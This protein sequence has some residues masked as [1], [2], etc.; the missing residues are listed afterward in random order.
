MSPTKAQT[1]ERCAYGDETQDDQDDDMIPEVVAVEGRTTT[2]V[3]IAALAAGEISVTSTTPEEDEDVNN[4]VRMAL[5]RARTPAMAFSGTTHMNATLRGG[6]AIGAGG[7]VKQ[8]VWRRAVNA[9]SE[10]LRSH[11]I[12]IT[13]P[14]PSPAFTWIT[15]MSILSVCKRLKKARVYLE[16]CDAAWRTV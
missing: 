6:R 4:A 1:H 16:T 9:D 2:M 10:L 13:L 11:S 14:L 7:G 12:S 15:S 8:R 5:L 3:G